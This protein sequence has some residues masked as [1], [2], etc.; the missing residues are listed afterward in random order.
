M[1]LGFFGGGGG[2]GIWFN[3]VF[4]CNRKCRES[5]LRVKL[6]SF[7]RGCGRSVVILSITET[8]NNDN[9]ALQK[10]IHV[11]LEHAEVHSRDRELLASHTGGLIRS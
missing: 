11:I 1:F 6:L 4:I 9:E 5:K 8:L 7:P 3:R 10:N 2:G